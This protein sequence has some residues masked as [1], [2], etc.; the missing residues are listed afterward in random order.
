MGPQWVQGAAAGTSASRGDRGMT[1]IQ[2]EEAF[3]MVAIDRDVQGKIL[4][5]LRDVYPRRAD[6]RAIKIGCDL[7]EIGANVAY[8]EEHSLVD[9]NWASGAPVAMVKITAKGLD[10]LV[11]DGGLSAILGVVTVRLHEDTLKALLIERI[12]SSSEPETVRSK[13]KDQIRALPAEGMKT[14][15]M[16]LLKQLLTRVPEV[17]PLL[18]KL[19]GP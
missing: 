16:E 12:D 18:Q 2:H 19:L 14:I 4:E 1:E 13:L 17:L 3:R 9:A 15:T 6:T 8:L 10:F 7:N 11:D 5:L